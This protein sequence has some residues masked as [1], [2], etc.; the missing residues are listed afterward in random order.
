MFCLYLTT[1]IDDKR[2]GRAKDLGA[3]LVI[4][5][6]GKTPEVI[7][8]EIKGQLGDLPHV[9]LECSGAPS[10]TNTGLQVVQTYFIPGELE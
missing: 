8:S 2:L 6:R 3:D 4:N 5:V 9:V 10:S 1:D 7:V